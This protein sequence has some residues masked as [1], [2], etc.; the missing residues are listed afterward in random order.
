MTNEEQQRANLQT[1]A[2]TI[3]QQTKAEMGEMLMQII[4]L[5]AKCLRLEAENEQLRAE[6][7]G[8]N[9]KNKG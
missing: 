5:K 2:I 1:E 3:N 4:V 7:E 8:K 6:K 9:Q